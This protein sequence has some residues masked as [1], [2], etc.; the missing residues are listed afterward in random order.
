MTTCPCCGI[1][2]PSEIAALEHY[3]A[4]KVCG[5]MWTLG[6]PPTMTYY[7]GLAG[8]NSADHRTLSEKISE[9]LE[10][11][12]TKLKDGLSILEIGCAEGLLGQRIKSE[13]RVLYI[14]IE[15]SN[16]AVIARDRLDRVYSTREELAV[17]M[18]NAK[19][20]L[21]LSFHV[22]EHIPDIAA[23]L[24]S[25][26]AMS[27]SK[28]Q[29]V[30][31]VPNEAG[32]PLLWLDRNFEHLHQFTGAS[33]AV[34]LVRHSFII[35][36]MRAGHFESA[37]YSDCLRITAR[38]STTRSQREAMLVDRLNQLFP[39]GFVVYGIGGDFDNYLRPILPLLRPGHLRAIHDSN[40]KR[41]GETIFSDLKIEPYCE[42]NNPVLISSYR[43]A[44]NIRTYLKACGLSEA[45]IFDLS[46]MLG[47][48][49]CDRQFQCPHEENYLPK[50]L[51]D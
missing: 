22:L 28:S 1:V 24:Q 12:R 30:I 46:D 5:H 16:D 45:K 49:G 42:Q 50:F 44:N 18:P 43:F 41:L 37:V 8:R 19:F 40:I 21:I 13:F 11:L 4:C 29:L 10:S 15:P 34:L 9:R 36:N 26:H 33:L 25:W 51:T 2:S 39:N 6:P 7:R 14:G 48:G 31:E 20:D 3:A 38:P 47:K 35:I 27:T 32:H 23:E 17:A